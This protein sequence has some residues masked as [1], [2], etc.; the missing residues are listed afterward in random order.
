MKISKFKEMLRQIQE[1]RGIKQESIIAALEEAMLSAAKKRFPNNENITVKIS[2][3]GETKVFDNDKE[4][5]PSDFGRLAAQT[6]K[7]VIVQRIRE[8]EKDGLFEEYITKVG[9]LITGVVQKRESGGYLV[10]IGRL[11]AYLGNME[12]IPGESY[13]TKDHVKMIVLE[14]KKSP[15]GPLVVLSR[16]NPDF[17]KKLFEMEVPEI[18]QGVL[19]IKG[20]AREAGRRTKI[21]IKSNDPNIGV[22]G[23]CVGQMGSRIQNV[24]REI[25]GERIDIIEW[26]DKPIKYIASALS[27]SKGGKI[28]IN[29]EE[30]AVKV[31]LGN[32]DLSLAIGKDG[33]NVRL[34]AKL[35][36][37]KIDIVS[38]EESEGKNQNKEGENG[39][40]ETPKKD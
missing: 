8:A 27:P 21:A 7:Q 17:I 23:T 26:S 34:A 1:E 18:E 20:I 11:E 31:I 4:V 16:S 15:K 38:E 30:R 24:T 22:I 9:Q 25:G 10:N 39:K 32:K 5:T 14:V 37:Y 2:D 12:M 40:E 3:A 13:R 6:A 19:E 28:E 36:G 33:Q 35:T 29:E